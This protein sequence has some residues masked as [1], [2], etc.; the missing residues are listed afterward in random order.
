MSNPV[1]SSPA[2]GRTEAR[3]AS[4]RAS[5]TMGSARAGVGGADVAVVS[6]ADGRPR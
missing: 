1:T 4:W 3:G 2:A 5:C 6:G